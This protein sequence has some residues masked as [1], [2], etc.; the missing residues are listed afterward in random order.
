MI[1]YAASNSIHY[2]FLSSSSSYCADKCSFY[3]GSVD[4]WIGQK[5][6]KSIPFTPVESS[7]I[8]IDG[9]TFYPGQQYYVVPNTNNNVMHY[10][11][12]VDE[13]VPIWTDGSGSCG[14]TTLP[15]CSPNI[16]TCPNGTP[17]NADGIAGT[18]CD[19]AT[20]DCSQCDAGYQLSAPAAFGS[21]STCG[22][23]PSCTASIV[24]TFKYLF[25]KYLL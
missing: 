25:V 18:L 17:T 15:S 13:K 20:V 21:A 19:T 5:N 7:R 4:G 16:C 23:I 22:V 3:S 2:Q 9:K 6:G 12:R 1:R 24:G 14:S 11:L 10:E 8:A